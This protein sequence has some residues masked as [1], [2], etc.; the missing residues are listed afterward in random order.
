MDSDLFLCLFKSLVWSILDYGSP[1]WNPSAKKNRQLLEN[2][3]RRG[4]RL[5]PELR[6]L[7]YKQRLEKLN[8]PSLFYRRRR[9]D[10][11]QI[12]KMIN[13]FEIIDTD[14]FFSFNDNITR[15]H[16]FKL[17]KSRC[18]KSM[19]L[20]SFPHRCI[21]D[22]NSL[23]EEIVCS[24]TVNGFKTKLDKLWKPTRFDIDQVY[25]LSKNIKYNNH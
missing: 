23:P 13:G 15:G 2:V 3:Q 4:T 19:R 18:N 5:V 9:Y 16:I 11:I 8:L 21:D 6:G 10:L 22:W 17:S 14:K 7:S 12:Y 24:E 1:V 20:N 25:W